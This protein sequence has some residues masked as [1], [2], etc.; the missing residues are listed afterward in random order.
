MSY[1]SGAM[2]VAAGISLAL[3]ITFPFIFLTTPAQTVETGAGLAWLIPLISGAPAVIML[4]AILYI[5]DKV[6]G[7]FYTVCRKLVGRVGA[8]AVAVY[9]ITLFFCD[10]VLLLR[11]FAENTLLT[12]LPRIEFSYVI[13]LYMAVAAIITYIGLEGILRANYIITPFGVLG[14]LIV[15][16]LLT[17]FCNVYNLLPWQGTGLDKVIPA[18]FLVAGAQAG[19][20]ALVILAP[21]FQNLKTIRTAMVLGLGMSAILK[22]LT[23]LVFLLVFCTTAAVEKVLPF[24]EMTRLVYLSR[25][26]QRIDS[27]FILLWVMIGVLAIAINFY[28][29]HYLITRLLNLPTMRPL[30]P[31]VSVIIAELAMLPPDI[32]TVITL[33]GVIITSYFNIGMYIIPSILIVA[34]MVRRKKKGAKQCAG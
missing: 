5:M 22:S 1:R 6:S 33:D 32:T 8:W 9:Y 28:M 11:Q 34:A 14:L 13:V 24:Y 25:Y 12:A 19:V 18:G 17:P 15:M 27:L 31:I 2:G 10:A 21:Y 4:L 29:G 30:I 26:L 20:F 7:D 16:L 23:V 3:L